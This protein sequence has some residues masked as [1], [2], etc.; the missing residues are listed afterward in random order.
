LGRNPALLLFFPTLKKNQPFHKRL[1]FAVHG[2]RAAWLGE[3]SFRTQ[4]LAVAFVV[5]VLVW[6]RPAPVWCALLLLNCGMVLAAELF[7]SA[8]EAA[9]DLLHPAPHPSVKLAKDCAAGAVL[10][11]SISAICVFIA[12]ILATFHL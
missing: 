8:L 4:C 12:F 11:L 10:M 7:N 2:L 6:R 5:A 9:L 1:G 3:A